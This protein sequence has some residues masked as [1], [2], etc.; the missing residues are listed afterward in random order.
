MAIAGL[1]AVIKPAVGRAEKRWPRLWGKRGMNALDLYCCAGGVSRGLMQSGFHVTGV[2]LCPQSNYCG[3]VFVQANALEYLATA[4]LSKFDFI[5]ASPPCQKFTAMRHAPGTKEH[6]D[7]IAPTR[8]LLVKI[9]K[10]YCIENVPGAP[11]INPITLC[12]SMFGLQAPDGAQLRRHRL[13][14]TSF[15]LLTPPCQHG[16]GSV[17]GIYGAHVRDRR[18]AQG[19]NHRGGSNRPWEHAFIAMGVPVGSMTLAELSEAIPPA[20]SRFVAEA[21]LAADAATPIAA[22]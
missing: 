4:D 3:D 10:P 8:E 14:E 20:Y 11:L 17:I 6:L 16:R 22:Q 9:G 18:R 7:L 15:P 5:W 12:G 13:F 19:F 21:F 1:A 2:D